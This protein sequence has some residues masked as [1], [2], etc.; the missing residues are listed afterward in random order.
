MLQREVRDMLSGT[1]FEGVQY[2]CGHKT[3]EDIDV[4]LDFWNYMKEAVLPLFINPLEVPA[5][6]RHRVLRTNQIVG[7]VVLQQVRRRA[8][9]CHDEYKKLGPFKQSA[10]G[11]KL[12]PM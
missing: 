3:L 10:Q 11:A 12:N 5:K 9:A 7:G 2:T 1:S 8:V 6:D 4:P